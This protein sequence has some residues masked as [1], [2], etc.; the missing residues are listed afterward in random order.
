MEG[1]TQTQTELA[2]CSTLECSVLA[3]NSHVSKLWSPWLKLLYFK[4]MTVPSYLVL[5]KPVVEDTVLLPKVT[6]VLACVFLHK[7]RLFS[8]VP[9]VLDCVGTKT[10]QKKISL[11]NILHQE[12]QWFLCREGRKLPLQEAPPD[13]PALQ[14]LP[15]SKSETLNILSRVSFVA[16]EISLFL[17]RLVS[18]ILASPWLVLFSV[19][20]YNHQY[21]I[22][23]THIFLSSMMMTSM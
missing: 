12:G 6:L 1:W 15:S 10:G 23:L 8:H 22:T 19:C 20:S 4:D 14:L 5:G 18:N 2:H 21:I 16:E 11:E 17:P 7:E 9:A 13:A 3:V